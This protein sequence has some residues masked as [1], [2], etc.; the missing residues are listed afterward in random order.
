MTICGAIHADNTAM[1]GPTYGHVILTSAN[2]LIS[3]LTVISIFA[4]KVSNI[5]TQEHKKEVAAFS[6][7]LDLDTQISML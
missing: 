5:D 3:T 6:F 2:P 4:I 1:Y 7:S